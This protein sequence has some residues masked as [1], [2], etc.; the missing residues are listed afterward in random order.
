MIFNQLEFIFVFFPILLILFF[1]G[2]TAYV[3]KPL[4]IA[5]SFLFYAVAGLEHATVLFL[6]ITW[7]HVLSRY[8]AVIRSGWGLAITIAGPALALTYYKYSS[9]L[10]SNIVDKQSIQSGGTFSMFENVLLPAGISFFTFQL[11]AYAIDRYRG[12]LPKPVGFIDLTL[13]ISF[14]PQLVAGPIVRFQQVQSAIASLSSWRPSREDIAQSIEYLV[15]G[16]AAK[17][18]IADTLL[19]YQAPLI[20]A[21][22]ELTVDGSIYLLFSYSFRI[23]FDFYCY[24]LI[25]IGLGRFFGFQL[26]TNFDRPYSAPNPKIFWRRW[27]ITLSYWIRDYVYLPLG[28][29][30][31]YLVNIFLIFALCGLWHGAAWRFVAWGIFHAVLVIAYSLTSRWW[32]RMPHLVQIALSFIVVSV[33]WTLFLFSFEDSITFMGS[34]LSFGT[35]EI[36]ADNL[37]MWAMLLVAAVVCF[38]IRI[39]SVIG[40]IRQSIWSRSAYSIMLSGVAVVTLVFVETSSTFIYFRF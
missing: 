21:P 17:V 23:Y 32:D 14:F 27:H 15:F 37:E 34:L 2:P 20:A 39:E 3:R 31:R 4:L 7:V 24:S 38:G 12:T 29:N 22:G 9:F 10:L 16:L 33:G 13:Y 8:G 35:G 28:G 6:A 18:L 30:K 25:A 5:F 26:P 36:G 11:I 1:W 19:R 40:Q